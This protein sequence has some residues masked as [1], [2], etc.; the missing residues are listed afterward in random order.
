[1]DT[2]SD[3]TLEDYFAAKIMQAM[4]TETGIASGDFAEVSYELAAKMM[5]VRNARRLGGPPNMGG[6][7]SEGIGAT[8][9]A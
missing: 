8:T 5:E 4:I 6:E 1:M 2:P 3:M 7:E 9:S